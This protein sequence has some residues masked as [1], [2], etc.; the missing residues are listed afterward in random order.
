MYRERLSSQSLIS[1]GLDYSAALHEMLIKRQNKITISSDHLD[2]FF[3][4]ATFSGNK[5]HKGLKK[6]SM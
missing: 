3:Q 6:H 2:T 4:A 1:K 5:P